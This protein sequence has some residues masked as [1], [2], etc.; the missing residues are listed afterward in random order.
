MDDY[1][2]HSMTSTKDALLNAGVRLIAERG[3]AS[4]SVGDIEEAAGFTRRG[5]ALYK[6]FRT[7]DDL[8]SEAIARHVESLS[9]PDGVLALLPLPDLRSELHLIGRWVLARLSAEEQISKIIEKEAVRL[10]HLV[11]TMRDH[12]S[13]PGY[14]LLGAYFIQRGLS[15][16]WD[17]EALAVLLLG[18]LINLRRS[19]WTFAKAPGDI[20]DERAVTTWVQLCSMLLATGPVLGKNEAV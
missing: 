12:I 15:A 13:E 4:V 2:H 10:P 8:L 11:E 5:G 1:S 7:K 14:T 18:S 19:A 3:F 17:A 20:E 16:V 9:Q 6:H